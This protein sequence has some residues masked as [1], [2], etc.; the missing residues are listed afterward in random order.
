MRNW[1]NC[2]LFAVTTGLLLSSCNLSVRD[3]FVIP[4]EFEEQEYIWLSWNETGFL[5]GEP[6]YTTVLEVIKEI[7][8]FVKVKIFYGPQLSYNKEQLKSRIYNVLVGSKIDTSR[9]ELF[10]NEIKYGAIQDPGPFFLRNKKGELAVAD[11]GFQHPD[12]RAEAI[13]RN[14][15]KQMGLPIISSTLIS[16]GGAWQTN[17][18][19]TMLLVESVELDRN[20]SMTKGQIEEEYKRVLGVT[21]IIWL[22]SGLKDEEWGKLD[23]GIYG[24]GTGG[25]IDEF[26]RFVNTNTVLLAEVNAMDTIGDEIAKESFLRLEESYQIL[27]QS[28]T[29]DGKS[30]EIIR[31][32]TGPMMTKKVNLTSLNKEEQSW[33][34]NPSSDSVEF[35]L[36]T[37]YMNFVIANGIIVTAKFWKEGL[38]NEFN[39]R[40]EM[41]KQILEKA[42]T[43]RKVVQVDCMPL[44]HD[45]AGLHCHSRNEPKS[46]R[47]KR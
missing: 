2:I 16:E 34:E 43:G 31:L 12:K 13:D 14:V 40:D 33:F 9:I 4:S 19:G 25:H 21:K 29:A 7:H 5:G 3:I 28:S 10:Y 24:I 26:C 11:F 38:P 27:K 37:G 8:P 6:Y 35:Y 45:G 17:G 36:A 22:K 15:A 18:E 46:V 47:A 23:N 20:K 30:L 32:P 42:F 39:E 1:F 44:H 41:A